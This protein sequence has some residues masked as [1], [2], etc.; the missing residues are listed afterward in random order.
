[1]EILLLG[2]VAFLIFG[3]VIIG[4]VWWWIDKNSL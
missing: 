3:L 4:I 2:L 1:M